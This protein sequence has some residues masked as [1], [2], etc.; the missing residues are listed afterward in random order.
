[1]SAFDDALNAGAELPVA[2]AGPAAFMGGPANLLTPLLGVAAAAA[3]GGPSSNYSPSD[4]RQNVSGTNH[5]GSGE[6]IVNLG[7]LQSVDFKKDQS[8][9]A[10]ANQDKP[11]GVF[12]G[13]GANMNM[14]KIALFAG[15]ALILILVIKKLKT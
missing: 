4:N 1:M 9:K 10:D 11:A 7:G 6:W 14:G 5:V 3:S 8:A 15:G 12:G 2:T 13:A